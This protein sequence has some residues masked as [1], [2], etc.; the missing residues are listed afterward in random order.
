MF[1]RP[2]GKLEIRVLKSADCN[3]LT[4][5]RINKWKCKAHQ[6]QKVG[7]KSYRLFFY[8]KDD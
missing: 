7:I 8:L 3:F 1:C 5:G 2:Y 6:T 4:L